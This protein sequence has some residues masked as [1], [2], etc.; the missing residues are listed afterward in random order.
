MS[1]TIEEKIAVMQAHA[2]GKAIEIHRGS[3]IWEEIGQPTWNWS[4]TDYRVKPIPTVRPYNNEEMLALVGKVVARKGFSLRC[5]IFYAGLWEVP[6]SGALY[7]WVRVTEDASI[8]AAR[9]LTDY[10][11]VGGSPCGVE[12]A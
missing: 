3:G 8:D 11:F 6:N 5:L 1:K 7:A 4:S 2:D 12:E 9:L 10:E